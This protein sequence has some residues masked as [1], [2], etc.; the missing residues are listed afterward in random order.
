MSKGNS[1]TLITTPLQHLHV[2]RK[3]EIPHCIRQIATGRRR[4][5]CGL[6]ISCPPT[7]SPRSA[8]GSSVSHAY[9]FVYEPIQCYTTQL[10]SWIYKISEE[11]DTSFGEIHSV[12]RANDGALNTTQKRKSIH[13]TIFHIFSQIL[14][15]TLP[16]LQTA[17]SHP[18]AQ[19]N[20]GSQSA[21]NF[22]K[23][24]VTKI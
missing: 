10:E 12:D 17:L 21:K 9:H 13:T 19:A 1:I 3:S 8:E 6:M 4:D 11:V 23:R 16:I 15:L 5:C 18:V 20:A 22:S 14:I 7:T 24:S 2:Q